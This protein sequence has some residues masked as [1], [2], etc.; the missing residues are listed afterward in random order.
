MPRFYSFDDWYSELLRVANDWRLD[1]RDV[2]SFPGWFWQSEFRRGELP[3][4]S[5]VSALQNAGLMG[6]NS[7]FI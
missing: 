6:D 7:Q 1:R 4:N 5:L 3:E 2:E